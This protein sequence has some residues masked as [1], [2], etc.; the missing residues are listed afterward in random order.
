MLS[1]KYGKGLHFCLAGDTNDLKLN[2]I[3][4]LAPNM[5]QIVTKPTK[6]DPKTGTEKILDPIIMT[7]SAYYQEPIYLDPLDN[8]P[9]KIGSPADHRIVITK[10]IN[11]INNKST[12]TSRVIHV[13]PITQSGLM[14]F[15][16]WLKNQSWNEIYDAKSAHDKAQIFQDM[17]LAQFDL[18]FSKKNIED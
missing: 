8:D 2:N 15:Q 14:K 17:L 10:P 4:N 5:I 9:N 6:I 13:Q 18:F 3:L 12:R 11:S 16:G 7:M 1:T